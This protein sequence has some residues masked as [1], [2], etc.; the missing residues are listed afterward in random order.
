LV[1]VTRHSGLCRT[2]KWSHRP[3][4]AYKKKKGKK[5]K[6]FS[7]NPEIFEVSRKNSA[8]AE[9]SNRQNGSRVTPHVDLNEIVQYMQEGQSLLDL[10]QR[11]YGVSCI[12]ILHSCS[13]NSHP[14]L[15]RQ[16]QTTYVA[17][18][19]VAYWT[20]AAMPYRIQ[21]LEGPV[22]N[23]YENLVEFYATM[24][25]IATVQLLRTK[26]VPKIFEWDCSNVSEL[27][28]ARP[29]LS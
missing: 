22:W 17:V 2:S 23:T 19:G 16:C 28:E 27:A 14:L 21:K 13:Y 15:A 6:N 3:Q 24:K 5:D 26:S 25:L 11:S 8:A 7:S 12:T 4:I 20:A 18:G 10:Y 1:E 29:E 9:M